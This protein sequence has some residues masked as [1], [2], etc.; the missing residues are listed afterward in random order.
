M[1]K[2]KKQ[3]AKELYYQTDLTKT[4]IANALGISRRAL[5]Y[6]IRAYR[7]EKMK[8]S[9][10]VLPSLLAEKCY[11][12]IGHLTDQY[13]DEM[14]MNKPVTYT[15]AETLYR[16][17]LTARKLKTHSTM[18]ERMEMFKDFHE[19]LARHDKKLSKALAPHIERYFVS[20]TYDTP[21][22]L[23]SK[24]YNENGRLVHHTGEGDPD[25]DFG[26]S[27]KHL[28][29]RDNYAWDA[30]KLET[31]TIKEPPMYPETPSGTTTTTHN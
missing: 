8:E 6:W 1:E 4:E 30:E 23:Q 2:G 18:N 27:E 9:A 22:S 24:D 25:G 10:N 21:M 11:H 12:I 15:E 17:M 31:G 19:R 16:L 14:R 29:E 28:D 5:H 26:P 3:E 20:D 13:L 7:W